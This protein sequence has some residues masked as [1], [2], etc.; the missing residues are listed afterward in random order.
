MSPAWRRAAPYGSPGA[1]ATAVRSTRCPATP[2]CRHRR[3]FIMARRKT[4]SIVAAL[5]FALAAAGGA[6]DARDLTVTAWGGSSQAAQKKVYYEPFMAKTGAKLLEDSWSGGIGVLRTKV[7][8]GNANWD[9]VQVEADEAILG[10]E[11]GLFE[12]LDWKALG[13]RDAFVKGASIDCAVG[14]VVWTTGLIYDGNR[15]K[16]GPKNWADFWN[17]DK[18]PG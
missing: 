18:F 8:G 2:A 6:A 7:K 4:L 5:S 9:V 3:S 13:G 15:F 1:R 14:A 12:K 11:E 17:V 16:D 10:C